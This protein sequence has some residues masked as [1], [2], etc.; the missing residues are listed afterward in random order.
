MILPAL[1]RVPTMSDVVEVP[2]QIA[3]RPARVLAR[4]DEAGLYHRLVLSTEGTGLDTTY[5]WPG[6]YLA[7]RVGGEPARYFA[8]AGDVA[9]RDRVELLVAPGSPTSDALGAVEVG[10]VIELS[11]AMGAGYPVE[12][13][14]GRPLV[15]FATGTGIAAVRPLVLWRAAEGD[16][17]RTILYQ[18]HTGRA[19]FA[20][21]WPGLVQ[22]GV[23]VV[24]VPPG[25]AGGFAQDR[26]AASPP[27]ED[28]RATEYV[29]CGS[30]AAQRAIEERLRGMGV[31]EA[32]I[33]YNWGRV[34]G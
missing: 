28:V 13:L 22:R 6:Q 5:R 9:Q 29:I 23:R 31:P 7:A 24:L 14:R 12:A 1:R 8:L 18:S 19:A 30:E 11:E 27:V 3:L 2:S 4:S 15:I 17:A 33:H 34:R 16:G 21:E 32:Q 10:D 20:T 26:F 25:G